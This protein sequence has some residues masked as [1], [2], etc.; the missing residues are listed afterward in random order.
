MDKPVF[1]KEESDTVEYIAKLKA[2]QA[3]T[4]GTVKEKIDRE[5][6]FASIGEF[7]ENNI[8]F[9]LKNS[10]MPMYILRDIHF[11]TGELSAQ[12]DYIVVTRKITFVIECKNLIGNIEIDNEGNFI[13]SY[14]LYGKRIREGIYSP[15][16]QNQRH[17]EILRQIKKEKKSNKILKIMFDKFFYENY[18]SIV[19]LANPKTVLNAGYAKKEIRQMVIRADQLNQY[20]KDV[21][22]N[23]KQPVFNDK[24]MKESAEGLLTLHTPNQADYAKKYEEIVSSIPRVSEKTHVE[25]QKA[26]KK[27]FNKKEQSVKIK[28]TSDHE[29]LVKN[30]KTFRLEKCKEENIKPYYIFNDKQMM[31]LIDKMPESREALLSV[32]GFGEVKV[33]KYGEKILQILS[34]FR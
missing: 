26:T 20:I 5:I 23:S 32:A 12:I 11:N 22:N 24:D 4:S 34:D 28:S 15:I 17:L 7:G 21:Y 9:E 8:A 6:K 10:G 18:K 14:E 27:Y 19:V 25:K 3:K 30:L 16:T 2:L 33:E 29:Q 1:L 31:D 13:R